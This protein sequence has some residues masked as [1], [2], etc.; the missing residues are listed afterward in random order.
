[1]VSI[2]IIPALSDN[3][4]FL[5]AAGKQ[6]III[7]PGAASPVLAAVQDADTTPA[8]ILITH[9]HADHIGG[10]AEIVAQYAD[11]EVYAPAGCPLA[12]TTTVAEGA[13][14]SLLGGK[15]CPT[16][17]HTP[18]HTAEHISFYAAG[19]IF[20]GDTVFACGCGRVLGGTVKQLQDSVAKIAAL[21]R[22][23]KV[24]CAHEYTENNIRFALSVD[25]NNERL[26]QRQATAAARRR[27]NLPTVPFVVEEELATNPFMRLQTTAIL[28]ATGNATDPFAELRRQKDNF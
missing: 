5:A 18:G 25:P 20:C 9:N 21:P 22:Q 13:H 2:K 10:V 6:S 8:A 23:T 11:I 4:I 3:Y 12:N 26:Q 1:M 24:Y 14:L 19:M 16:I 28:A 7:D 17:M 27:Q 15:F